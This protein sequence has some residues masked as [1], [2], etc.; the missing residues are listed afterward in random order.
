VTTLALLDDGVRR[1]A[2]DTIVGY[3]LRDGGT[4]DGRK[5]G[6]VIA[7]SAACTHMG[8][9]VQWHASD[10]TFHCPRH[11]GIFTEDGLVDKRS[12][13]RGYLAPLPRLE[14]KVEDGKVYVK[15]PVGQ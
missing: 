4:N 5:Q 6:Q 10:R 3:V 14:T 12:S 7:L 15:V 11:G 2:T 1:F 8:C 13:V 9:I